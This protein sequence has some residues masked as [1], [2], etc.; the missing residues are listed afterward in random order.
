MKSCLSGQAVPNQG[1]GVS[2]LVPAQTS[3]CLRQRSPRNTVMILAGINGVM[4]TVILQSRGLKEGQPRW[5]GPWLF[6]LNKH[7]CENRSHL[8]GWCKDILCGTSLDM[9]SHMVHKK[10]V[11]E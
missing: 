3:A 7:A 8:P 9:A 6:V 10:D 2:M 11:G 4:Q 5:K 1:T